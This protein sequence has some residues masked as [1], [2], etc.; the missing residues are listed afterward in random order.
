MFRE[1]PRSKKTL[2]NEL[3]VPG[4]SDSRRLDQ[5]IVP[6]MSPS[7][8]LQ[9]STVLPSAVTIGSSQNPWR[10][11]STD[12]LFAAFPSITSASATAV[13]PVAANP[14]ANGG[15]HWHV[16]LPAAAAD[17]KV[18]RWNGSAW[19]DYTSQL[20]PGAIFYNAGSTFL[21][22]YVWAGPRDGA[23]FGLRAAFGSPDF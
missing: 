5:D 19:E 14:T 11:V 10:S 20:T 8:L 7:W 4:S 23:N 3:N 9:P 2:T 22:V 16:E 1:T 17:R 6:I 15:R 13:P 18:W 21:R 12:Y